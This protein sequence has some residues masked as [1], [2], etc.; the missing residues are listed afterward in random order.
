[1]LSAS[2]KTVF[3]TVSNATGIKSAIACITVF[4][5]PGNAAVM[6]A[7]NCTTA[8]NMSGATPVTAST[9]PGNVATTA[10]INS[11][12]PSTSAGSISATSDGIPFAIS[13]P[14]SEIAV[15]RVDNTCLMTGSRLL[16]NVF[17][18]LIKSFNASSKSASGFA[19]ATIKFSHAAFVIPNDP[20]KVVAASFAVVPVI[21]ICSCT[22]WIAFT[23]L[24]NERL[25]AFILLS[26]AAASRTSRFISSC[27]PP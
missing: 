17:A 18:E 13:T 1:M 7:N 21:P 25:F 19:S 22:T 20:C 6:S 4:I 23:T 14:N 26:T 9:S 27:V 10:F 24:S 8:F 12:A 3:K 2:D 5:S 11:A 16:A 15:G